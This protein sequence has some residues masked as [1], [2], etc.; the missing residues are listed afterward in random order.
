MGET[1]EGAFRMI[2]PIGVI[3]RG[4]QSFVRERL[5]EYD[6]V[7]VEAFALRMIASLD[8]CN[9]DTL[10]TRL[11]IDKGRVAKLLAGLENAGQ[12]TRTVNEN[13][14]REKLVRLTERGQEALQYVNETLDEWNRMCMQGF[15]EEEWTQF[16]SFLHRIADNVAHS[17]KEGWP[18]L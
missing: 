3:R 9:Q 1:T 7:P 13:N 8:G 2:H 14:K 12:I 5:K 17:R 18:K 10:C 15:T 16:F 11:E 6:L 4:E